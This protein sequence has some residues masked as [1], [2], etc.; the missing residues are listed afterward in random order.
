MVPDWVNLPLVFV[1]I[2]AATGA[3]V[4]LDR[5]YLRP[6]REASNVKEVPAYVDFSRGFFPIFAVI[7]VL[8]S[9]VFE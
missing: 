5:F 7:L 3:V 1:I 4:L 2:T 8:R 6:Q 9:F